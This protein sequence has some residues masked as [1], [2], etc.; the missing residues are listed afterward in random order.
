M[1]DLALPLTLAA[2]SLFPAL[3]FT[4]PA[5]GFQEQEAPKKKV[6]P[7]VH[8][9]VRA[10]AAA[11][12]EDLVLDGTIRVEQPRGGHLGELGL[13]AGA[14][15]A[16]QIMGGG[17]DFAIGG[18]SPYEGELE[19]ARAPSGELII[20]SKKVAP[21]FVLYEDGPLRLLQ[22]LQ[23]K[24]KIRLGNL[25]AELS[26]FLDLEAMI[27]LLQK[28]EFVAV[29]NEQDLTV[30]YKFE[31]P[32]KF[33]KHKRANMPMGMLGGIEEIHATVTMRP[34][35]DELSSLTFEVVRHN[36]FANFMNAQFVV[37]AI[38]MEIADEVDGDGPDE[39][40]DEAPEEAP[41]A[42]KK[43]EWKAVN[44]RAT[45]EGAKKDPGP[46]TIFE[47]KRKISGEKSRRLALV[48]ER[49]REDVEE[50]DHQ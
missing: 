6:A 28:A 14:G 8:P 31:V 40:P 24:E 15:G 13:V 35:L 46:K 43:P 16:I 25:E 49:M 33:L 47:F 27:P 41:E 19:I 20:A 42:D 2:A 45:E 38:E 5:A 37:D 30:G 4:A 10:F 48:L 7:T 18:S 39:A 9:V 1:K 36:P 23:S 3:V 50:I 34:G 44:I 32:T 29:K 11:A 22:L 21:G 26:K 12:R 17:G